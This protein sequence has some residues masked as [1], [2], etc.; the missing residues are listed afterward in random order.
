MS[1][2]KAGLAN[3]WLP[4]FKNEKKKVQN[5]SGHC[6]RKIKSE[7]LQCNTRILLHILK[8]KKN[9]NQKNFA[10]SAFTLD[11]LYSIT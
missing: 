9:V 1:D 2:L 6:L 8:K 10:S 11:V 4:F 5:F 3:F 7:N